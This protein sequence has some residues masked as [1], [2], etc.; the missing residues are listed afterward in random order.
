MKTPICEICLKSGILCPACTDNVE[1]GLVKQENIASL[2][3]MK[4]LSARIRPLHGI[5]IKRLIDTGEIMVVVC[6]RDDVKRMVGRGGTIIKNLTRAVGK[7]VRVIEDSDD[8]KT[9]LE[10]L[11]FPF[12]VLS[13]GTVYKKCGEAIRMRIPREGRLPIPE[14]SI[15]E[16][17][18]QVFGQEV[19]VLPE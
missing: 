13:V 9:F 5:E 4:E 14:R 10:M 19:E 3:K 8:P 11:V 17:F 18:M 16:I 1:K 2:R 7:K 12:P 15:S 6:G